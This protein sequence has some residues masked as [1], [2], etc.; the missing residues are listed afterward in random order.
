[1]MPQKLFKGRNFELSKSHVQVI[2]SLLYSLLI[3]ALASFVVIVC[4][5][6]S[7]VGFLVCD[8]VSPVC[9]SNLPAEL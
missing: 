9:I 3:V 8:L 1:M 2:L 5:K 4:L 7:L 6:R